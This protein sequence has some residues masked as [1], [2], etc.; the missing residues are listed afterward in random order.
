MKFGIG[1]KLVL[2]ATTL[3]FVT[4][5]LLLWSMKR[6]STDIV[7]DHEILDLGDETRL[8]AS[9]LMS[10]IYAVRTDV[11]SLAREEEVGQLRT[12]VPGD[13]DQAKLEDLCRKKFYRPNYLWLEVVTVGADGQRKTFVVLQ[14]PIQPPTGF[15]RAVWVENRDDFLEQL[16]HHKPGGATEPQPMVSKIRRMG[17]R[18]AGSQGVDR[19]NILWAGKQLVSPRDHPTGQAVAVI[20]ALNLDA[21]LPCGSGSSKDGRSSLHR[22]NASPRHL[23][24]LANEPENGRPFTD[25][26]LVY[27]YEPELQRISREDMV[28]PFTELFLERDSL[29]EA[30]EKSQPQ[31]ETRQV[32]DYPKQEVRLREPLW[33]RQST[34]I[35]T[36]DHEAATVAVT[37]FAQTL[38]GGQRI[39]HLLGGVKNVRLLARSKRDVVGLSQQVD[40]LPAIDVGWQAP[41]ACEECY[42]RFVLFPVRSAGA[43]GG[44]RYFGLAQAAFKEEMEADVDAEMTSLLWC[45]GG[46][47]LLAAVLASACS[48]IF[49]RPLKQITATAQAVAEMDIDTVSRDDSWRNRVSE[50]VERLPVKRRDE[51]GVLARAFRQMLDEVAESH[52]RLRHLNADL[53]RRVRERTKELELA[54]AELTAARDKAHELSRA[55]DAFLASV[56]HELRNPLNQVSGFCQLLELTDLDDEQ[57]ADVQKIRLAGSQLLTLINDILDYQ[58]IIMG[59]ITLEPEELQVSKLVKE[60]GDAMEFPA[61]DNGNRLEIHCGDDVGNLYADEQRVRQILL[62]LVGNACKL[63]QNG[64]V[65]LQATRE[66]N[67]DAGVIR[68]DVQD[69]GRGM[70]AEEQAKLFRPFTKLAAK[71]GN[72]SGTGLGLVICKGF[73]DMM[74]GAI[75]VKSEFG[76][77]S[78]F[79]VRLPVDTIQGRAVQ[80]AAETAQAATPS[81]DELAEEAATMAEPP[82]PRAAVAKRPRPVGT[83]GPLSAD[84]ARVVL[85]VDDDPGVRELMN[86]YLETQGFHVLTAA[87]GIEGLEMAKRLHPAVITLDAVMPGLDGWAVLAA[88]RTDPETSRIPVVMVTITDDE[89]RS[90]SLGAAEFVSKPVDWEKLTRVLSKYTGN[91]RDRSVLVVDDEPRARE[92]LRRNLERDGWEVLEAE[93]GKAALELLATEQPAV[94]LLDLM[95]PVMDGFEFL[96]SYCQLAE[97]LSI[98]VVVVSAKDPSPEELDRLDGHVVRVL[99]KGQYSN[100]DLLREIH[101]RVDKH[102]KS[103]ERETQEVRDVENTRGR[104]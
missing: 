67:G 30:C 18:Y 63:T 88:L 42:V 36:A 45:A 54:N 25:D 86:R 44:T 71:Q 19:S 22:M 83:A 93:H 81:S 10:E 99:R 28:K 31:Q 2:L 20:A 1:V 55:K 72:R 50:I 14:E 66:Q 87:T 77:G 4:A 92:I 78:T 48:L 82:Q 46:F 16:L 7:L 102:L 29:A 34:E 104:G 13:D 61:R 89:Q 26:L 70:T 37:A 39:G 57:L 80:P 101:R 11:D 47:V 73:C 56:S 75:T 91:K 85:V 97:W 84:S 52:E 98:P 79:T 100:E 33:F 64:T 43:K 65:R 74:H 51:I 96:A 12:R 38:T 15:R 68:F 17:V 27:P 95:M 62:N 8:R 3:V 49:T 9:E 23:A 21:N 76:K 41:V 32:I 58:K 40:G 35:H 5:S 24:V 6:G 94:I 69:T 59:G 90:Y 103:E 60:V 53:D